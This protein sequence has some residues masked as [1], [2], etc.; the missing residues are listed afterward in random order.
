MPI[1]SQSK[2]KIP[3]TVWTLGFISFFNDISSEMLYPILPI[4]L[5]QV[6]GASVLVV[7]IIEGLA[8]ATASFCKILF[9]Y[10]S[11]SLQRRK[12]FVIAG[13]GAAAIAKIIIAFSQVWFVVY[14][15]RLLDRVGKGMRTGARDALLLEAADEN[16]KGLIFGLH[17]SMDSA[18]A[19][20]G[21]IIVLVLLY[22]Y[23]N[24]IRTILYVAAF[25]T[26]LSLFLFFFLKEAKKNVKVSKIQ[27]SLS[28]KQ[29]PKA[30]Q[31]FL[32]GFAIFSLGN[33]SDTFLILK[34]KSLGMNLFSVIFAYVVYNL[35]YTIVSTPAG[36]LA[37]KIGAKKVFLFGI[38]IFA[39]VYLGFAVN[40]QP[41]FV[42][43]LF[44]IYGFYI[45]FTDGVSKAIVGSFIPKEQSGTAYGVVYTISSFLGLFASV[46]G[47]L[48][49]SFVSP[50]APFFFA[51]VCALISCVILGKYMLSSHVGQASLSTKQSSSVVAQKQTKLLIVIGLVFLFGSVIALTLVQQYYHPTITHSKG[52]TTHRKE[53]F[54]TSIYP[55]FAHKI[56]PGDISPETEQALS[57]FILQKKKFSNGTIEVK[58]RPVAKGYQF[59]TFLVKPGYSMYFATLPDAEGEIND[60]YTIDYLYYDVPVLVDNKGYIINL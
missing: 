2:N 51:A 40:T 22:L 13:Y 54:S 9:G 14:V 12:P 38:L 15:G 24:N 60:T 26:I 41:F 56:A 53:K 6:L 48:L 31:F 34:A 57:Y 8:E 36:R 45:A 35:F 21:P 43:I 1:R 32:I 30:F 50:S 17:R 46:I 11:D 33:S 18:G 28:L 59:E 37:D 58:L 44:A 39:F 7:G 49:W 55:P 16:N 19:V 29:F 4:F 20:I 52:Q 47:G 10:W 27:V 42:W 3:K 25:P 5:T 23:H